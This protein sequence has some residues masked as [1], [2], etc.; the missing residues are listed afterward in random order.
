MEFECRSAIKKL[1]LKKFN[2]SAL[3]LVYF[4]LLAHCV[5]SSYSAFI[6]SVTPPIKRWV[7]RFRPSVPRGLWPSMCGSLS[8]LSMALRRLRVTTSWCQ[9]PCSSWTWLTTVPVPEPVLNLR[10]RG[11]K[12]LAWHT[13]YQFTSEGGYLP[14]TLF[15]LY[16][17]VPN[18]EEKSAHIAQQDEERWQTSI[19]DSTL[20]DWNEAHFCIWHPD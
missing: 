12:S 13:S 20:C 11:T 17:A 19:W 15:I 3:C 1:K 4:L 6:S 18:E 16:Q 2:I 10:G 7:S 14:N 9:R 5:T 8:T